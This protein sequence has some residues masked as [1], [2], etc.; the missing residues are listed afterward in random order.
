MLAVSS[1]TWISLGISILASII[2]TIVVLLTR[3]F[4][5]R[6]RDALP[7]GSLFRGIANV[8]DPCLVFI[9]RMTDLEKTGKFKTP[10]PSSTIPRESQPLHTVKYDMNQNIPW[11][12]STATAQAMAHV[13]NVLGR[14]GRTDNIELTFHDKDY[15]RWDA[16]MFIVGGGWKRDRAVRT[17]KPYVQIQQNGFVLNE[18]EEVFA[19]Q[20]ADEDIGLLQK[21][22]NPTNSQTVWILDGFRGIGVTAASYS[23]VRWWKQLGWIYGNKPFAL[24]V[25]VN[26]KDGWQQ[27][28]I[29]K[30]H[31]PPKFLTKL[32]HRYSWRVLKNAYKET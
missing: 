6:I 22:I 1:Q 18:T 12:T 11:V 31:P 7:A 9:R 14:A 26:E 23:L 30:L 24:L 3:L 27:S 28:H 8:S 13:L 2:V 32:V 25:R 10:R 29:I 19:P 21:T 15:D 5:Y 20:K 4:F 16:P 17:C